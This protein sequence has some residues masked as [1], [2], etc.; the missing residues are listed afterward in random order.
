MEQEQQ[1][2]RIETFQV[3][4]NQNEKP[5]HFSSIKMKKEIL[6]MSVLNKQTEKKNDTKKMFGFRFQ[7]VG[8][9]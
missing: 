7:K 6:P 3:Q 1:Y 9:V 8:N 4:K 2:H 5:S